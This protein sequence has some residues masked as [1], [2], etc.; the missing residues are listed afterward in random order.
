MLHDYQRWP[1]FTVKELSC[2]HTGKEN[3]DVQG[4]E[5][6]MDGIQDLRDWYGKPMNVSSCYRDPTHPN[7]RDK[8]VAGEHTRFAIDFR[9]P[10]A[11]CWEML[12]ECFLRGYTG[13]GVNLTGD[14]AYRF[15]H[16]DTRLTAR[17]VWSY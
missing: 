5:D 2:S 9:I 14:P 7:E 10:T 16:I 15:I 1:N 6:F 8:Q 11:D 13:I 4:F 3:P 12:A 17:R